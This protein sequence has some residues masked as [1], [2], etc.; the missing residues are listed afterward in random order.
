MAFSQHTV[1]GGAL[2][3]IVVAAVIGG[4]A[5]VGG[6]GHARKEREDSRREDALDATARAVACYKQATGAVPEDL[7][8]GES[9]LTA[10]DA[11]TRSK[12]HCDNPKVEADPVSH[13]PFRLQSGPNGDIEICAVFALP[14]EGRAEDNWRL[15]R[16]DSALPGLTEPRE[17]A[18]EHCFVINFGS[19]LD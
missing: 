4:I 9:I 5:V 7:S 18:G 15:T 14:R 10:I 6:P 3:A 13:Q 12:G 1:F 19:A 2:A 17:T 16:K 11:E 8:D